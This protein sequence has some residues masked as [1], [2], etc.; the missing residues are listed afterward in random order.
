MCVNSCSYV[1]ISALNTCIQLMRQE[2]QQQPNPNTSNTLKVL[3]AFMYST[4]TQ[5]AFQK[6]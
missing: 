3:E 5:N 2:K 6:K 1:G 4:E